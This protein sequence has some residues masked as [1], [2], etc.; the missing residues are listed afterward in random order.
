[1][2]KVLFNFLVHR[3]DSNPPNSHG[4]YLPAISKIKQVLY[5]DLA[6]SQCAVLVLFMSDGKP[7]DVVAR[8]PG[9]I[10]EK[11]VRLWISSF[12]CK[13]LLFGFLYLKT[14]IQLLLLHILVAKGCIHYSTNSPRIGPAFWSSFDVWRNWICI[15]GNTIW[16][17]TWNGTNSHRRWRG[18]HS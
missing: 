15:T 8:G 4:N 14:F 9:T 10:T 5:S 13:C 11:Q 7:S 1:M 6:N 18:M 16:R 12:I 3:A 2:T 17:T